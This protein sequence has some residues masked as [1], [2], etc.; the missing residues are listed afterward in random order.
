MSAPHRL[1][2]GAGSDTFRE[3]RL[4]YR[5]P[6]NQPAHVAVLVLGAATQPQGDRVS[7]LKAALFDMDGTLVDSTTTVE[8]V[9]TEIASTY[10]LDVQE[11]LATAHGV[12]AAD[13]MRRFL[14]EDK[15]AE[16][17]TALE[18][19]EISLVDG[20]V[21][22]PGAAAY[23]AHLRS[24][25]VAVAIVT[26]ASP[27]LA[28]ARIRAAG[29]TIP[30]VLVTAADVAHGKPAPDGYQLAAERLGVNVED[31]VVFEDA[32]AGIRAGLAS[33]AAVV[34]VGDW[35]SDATENLRRVQDYREI[36]TGIQTDPLSLR[37]GTA[38][39]GA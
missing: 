39:P 34:V 2:L 21:E 17:V 33:G 16:A 32:E 13:T 20:V 11:I 35:E 1:A 5:L 30:D 31:C 10:G 38:G 25:G 3:L 36:L 8:L 22:V 27:A 29:L 28:R 15:V 7:K 12:R 26:S 14:A 18:K 4:V 24:A 23:L 37:A 19:R 6:E 9:W